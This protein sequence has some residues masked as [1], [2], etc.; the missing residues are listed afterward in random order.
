MSQAVQAPTTS[1]SNTAEVLTYLS[2][3]ARSRRLAASCLNPADHK[4]N[5]RLWVSLAR[6]A[7]LEGRCA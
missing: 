2:M 5:H 7:R 4:V 3:A 6:R 1:S